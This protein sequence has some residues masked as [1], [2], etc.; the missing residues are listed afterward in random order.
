LGPG[1]GNRLGGPLD[2]LDTPSLLGVW[3]TPPYLH[4][5]S[6]A[7]LEEVLTARNPLDQHGTTSTLDPSQLQALV[8]FLRELDGS[9]PPFPGPGD[10]FFAD[11][12]EDGTT[13]AWSA[14]VP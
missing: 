8:A 7:T 3:A 14:A 2:G 13:G 10:P 11:G 5:G 6:A 9:E 4:D 1:S 12:F